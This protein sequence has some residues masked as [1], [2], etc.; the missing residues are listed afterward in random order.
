MS[1]DNIFPVIQCAFSVWQDVYI[2]TH[3]DRRLNGCK[4]VQYN[5]GCK[6][7][8]PDIGD[9]DVTDKQGD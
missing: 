4:C 9:I 5:H 7:Y 3:T 8:E 6:R 2:C 1:R